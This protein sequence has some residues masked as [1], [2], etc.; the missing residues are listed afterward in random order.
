MSEQIKCGGHA[1]ANA[2][3]VGIIP[4]RSSRTET[5]WLGG[6]SVRPKAALSGRYRV[7]RYDQPGYDRS[8][9]W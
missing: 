3:V 9:P 2:V 8:K 5:P 6:Q 4:C 7:V 1:A